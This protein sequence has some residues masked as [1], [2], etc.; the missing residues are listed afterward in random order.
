MGFAGGGG[1]LS[2]TGSLGGGY[3]RVDVFPEG[4][5][6]ANGRDLKGLH[7]AFATNTSDL[8][9]GAAARV[10]DLMD[11]MAIATA[12]TAVPASLDYWPQA[13]E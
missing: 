7:I 8:P 2:Y 11:R 9:D 4:Y 6:S 5:V 12:D 13:W 1:K 3:A 10:S